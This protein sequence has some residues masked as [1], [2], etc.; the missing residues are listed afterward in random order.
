LV[1]KFDTPIYHPNI[2][3]QTGVICLDILKDAW[4]PAYS[5]RSVILSI[6]A[7][8]SSPEPSDPQD[9]EAASLYLNHHDEFERTAKFWTEAYATKS[10]MEEQV[11]KG[12]RITRS[13]KRDRKHAEHEAPHSSKRSKIPG[14]VQRLQEL[15][16]SQDAVQAALTQTNGDETL[17]IELLL[18]T[19]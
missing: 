18:H 12:T 17:A 1:V 3:S 14:A 10:T 2:S 13:T 9:A 15:G 11:V 8:L 16:F 5:V 7:L 19:D 6:Q 4:S